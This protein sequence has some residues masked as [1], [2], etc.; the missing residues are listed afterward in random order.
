VIVTVWPSGW[1]CDHWTSVRGTDLT[2]KRIY[3]TNYAG[4]TPRGGCPGRTSRGCG[5]REGA[6]SFVRRL[7]NHLPPDRRTARG[8]PAMITRARPGGGSLPL[9]AALRLGSGGYLSLPGRDTTVLGAAG[10]W[11]AA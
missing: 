2:G 10:G 6:A 5:S 4:A 1:C 7:E 9:R 8:P 11:A 3:L